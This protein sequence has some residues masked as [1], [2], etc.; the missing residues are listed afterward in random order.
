MDEYYSTHTCI[1]PEA[2][3]ISCDSS[4]SRILL[5]ELEQILVYIVG[6]KIEQFKWSS[7]QLD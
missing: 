5:G 7:L 3:T 6:S 1:H 4:S 2:E